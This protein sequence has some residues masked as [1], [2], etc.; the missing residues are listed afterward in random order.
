MFNLIKELWPMQANVRWVLWRSTLCWILSCGDSGISRQRR[1]LEDPRLQRSDRHQPIPQTDQQSHLVYVIIRCHRSGTCPT[2][3]TTTPTTAAATATTIILSVLLF[4]VFG[5]FR[6]Q[7]LRGRWLYV[8][9]Q[10]STSSAAGATR[11]QQLDEVKSGNRRKWT[12]FRCNRL[13]FG[14]RYQFCQLEE[15]H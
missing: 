9:G 7:S 10:K 3:T 5:T 15:A 2:V 8:K 1:W 14:Y 4:G 12:S 11:I 6:F 13:R